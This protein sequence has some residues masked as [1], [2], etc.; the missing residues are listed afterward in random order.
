MKLA[1]VATI[2][3]AVCLLFSYLTLDSG[4]DD[5][6]VRTQEMLGDYVEVGIWTSE[7]HQNDYRLVLVNQGE[8]DSEYVLWVDGL[9]EG[10]YTAP[11]GLIV[12]CVLCDVE[13]L[14]FVDQETIQMIPEDVACDVYT[15]GDKT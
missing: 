10:I 11:N 3:I 14:T 9:Y 5:G 4:S 7:G 15:E 2:V 13:G 12:T 8:Q 6:G 1:A